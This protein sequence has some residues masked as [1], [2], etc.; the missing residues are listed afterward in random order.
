MEA[1]APAIDG[2][3]RRT[4]AGGGGGVGEGSSRWATLF[5]PS[6]GFVFCHVEYLVQGRLCR[7]LNL[8][9]FLHELRAACSAARDGMWHG[10]APYPTRQHL[11]QRR[12]SGSVLACML[13]FC[14][15]ALFM[16]Y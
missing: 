5:I 7:K 1:R 16:L 4:E 11:P 13:K 3:A 6:L 2:K 12:Q 9:R 15:S 8:R 10:A 14:E